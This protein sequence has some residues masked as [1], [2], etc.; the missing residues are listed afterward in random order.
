MQSTVIKNYLISAIRNIK[1]QPFIS[2]INIFGLAVGLTCCLL[3]LSYIIN[4]RS[5]DKFNTNAKDIR[6]VT[7]I[8][9][10]NKIESLHLS[11]VA[12]PFGPLLQTAFPDIKKVTRV[13]PIKTTAFHYNDRLFNEQNSVFADENFFDFFTIPVIRGNQNSALK[14]PYSIMLSENMAK[15]YFGDADPMNKG[16][17]LDNIFLGKIQHDFKVTGIFKSFPAKYRRI[18]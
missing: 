4:E 3:I 15:K 5:Y 18:P 7:R 13:L 11:A 2:L 9:Y 10:G 17:Y 14:S 12:P 8:F 1:K 6:R 16:I